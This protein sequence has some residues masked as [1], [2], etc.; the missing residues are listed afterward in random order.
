MKCFICPL[1]RQLIPV[2]LFIPVLSAG[3]V[4]GQ[5]SITKSD[6]HGRESYVLRNSQMLVRLLTGGAY[7]SEVRLLTS[8]GQ[9]SVNPLFLPH[10]QTI[11]PHDYQPENH[12]QLYGI[13]KNAKLM[14]GYMGHY[15]CFPYFGGAISGAEEELGYSTHGEAYTVKYSID[16]SVEDEAVTVTAS[17]VL[18]MTKYRVTRRLTLLSEQSV[19]LVEEAVENLKDV[20]RPYHWVQHVTFGP[21]FIEYGKTKVDAPVSRIAFSPNKDD[22]KNLNTVMWP[23]VLT[24][25]GDT[26]Y[27][28]IFNSD[29]GEGGYSAWLM[30][31]AREYTW[32]TM[33]H[34]D[35][36]LLIGYI[37]SKDENPWIGDWQENHRSQALPRNGKTVAWGLEVGTTPFGSGIKNIEQEPVFNTK[38]YDWIGAN[39]KKQ[40]SY[41]IFLMEVEDGFHGVKHLELEKEAIILEEKRSGKQMVLTHKFD[42]SLFSK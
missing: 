20:R 29:Q 17:A 11:D 16:E 5:V 9:Q 10:Y 39:Q 26:L 18:P 25:A 34:Q 32:F 4:F 23:T 38:T 22:D 2:L 30:D 40:Q 14:A 15:L 24:E 1:F 13:G 19:L 37:F 33:Y 36:K 28:G 27:A 31:P 12:Q 35:L 21:P 42:L 8:E 41:L 6:F 7:M 3:T